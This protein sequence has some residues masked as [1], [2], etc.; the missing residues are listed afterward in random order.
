MRLR[1]AVR[2]DRDYRHHR[3][4][5]ARKTMSRGSERMRSAGKALAGVE[6]AILDA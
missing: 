2:H 6:L 1:A 5:A 4:A 3:G